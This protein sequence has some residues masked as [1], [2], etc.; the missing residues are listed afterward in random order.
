[1]RHSELGAEPNN[2]LADNGQSPRSESLETTGRSIQA[3]E[4]AD[5]HGVDDASG[6]CK[7]KQGLQA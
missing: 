5:S 1:M 2:P 6:L 4:D 7:I 3:N